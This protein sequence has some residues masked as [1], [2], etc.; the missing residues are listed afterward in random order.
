VC[1]YVTC[2]FQDV[3]VQLL[4]SGA[5]LCAVGFISAMVVGILD[6]A[7]VQQLGQDNI[8]QQESKKVVCTETSNNIIL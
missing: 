8:M 6:K 7:G 4:C 1:C 5:L 3:S 2:N